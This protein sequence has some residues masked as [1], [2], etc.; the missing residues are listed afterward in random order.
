M[1]EFRTLVQRIKPDFRGRFGGD[2]KYQKGTSES[3]SVR[4]VLTRAADFKD[5]LID[6]LFWLVRPC[7][8][9]KMTEDVFVRALARLFKP[10]SD[11]SF[12]MQVPKSQHM[13]R[14]IFGEQPKSAAAAVTVIFNALYNENPGLILYPFYGDISRGEAE[15][16][17]AAADSG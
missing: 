8:S 16:I 5:I 1:D 11:F 13:R 6:R 2:G 17:L 4:D 12:T 3:N 14:F 15:E 9:G 10:P 7:D